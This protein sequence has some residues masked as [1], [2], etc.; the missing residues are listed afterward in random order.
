M[1]AKV[2][3]FLNFKGGVGKT[4]GAVNLAAC[5][6]K[7]LD[8]HVL[9]VDLDPQ[10]NASFWLYAPQACREFTK[11][12]RRSTFQIFL[13][14]VQ[15][16]Q[17]FDF[18]SALLT[19]LP[20]IDGYPGIPKLDLLP[21]DIELIK[22]EDRIHQNRFATQFFRFLYKTLKP[23]FERYDYVFLDCPPNVYSV[24]KNALFAA[25]CCVVPY[26]PDFLSLTGFQ[27]L[28]EQIQEFNQRVSGFRQ[29]RSPCEIAA[30]M[31]NHYRSRVTH[32]ASAVEE[33]KNIVAHLRA[34]GLI[35]QRCELLTPFVRT[36]AAVASSTE[37]HQPVCVSNENSI[38]NEDFYHL[39]LNLD[40]HLRRLK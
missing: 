2:V 40:G 39:A 29:G 12:G 24:S 3:A 27:I 19:G 32:A 26:M 9:L 8:K 31:I 10:C 5:F 23:Y 15:G 18:D 37:V 16:T 6:S 25:D 7:Y 35:H 17:L 34:E 4:A 13:D 33:L 20:R 30:L 11:G 36:C 1:G 21:A 38:G 22:V 14:H 28:A